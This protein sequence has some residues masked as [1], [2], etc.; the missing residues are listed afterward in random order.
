MPDDT[1][2]EPTPLLAPAAGVPPVLRDQAG[3]VAAAAALAAGDGPLAVDAERASGFK[4]SGRAYLIQLRRAG[5]GSFL[6]DP[7]GATGLSELATVV[8]SLEWILHSADQDLPCL[9]E[10]GLRPAQLYDTEL[11]GRLAGFER[12][13]LAA[14]VEHTL[15]LGLQKGHGAA[16]WSQRPLPPDWLN[17]AALDVEVL[18]ELYAAMHAELAAQNKTEWAA[19]EFEYIRTLP[20]PPPKPDRWRRTS[21]IHT[22]RKP[23]QLAAVRELW[24]T[25]DQ[26]A[27]DTDIAPGRVLPDA[28]IV[29]AVKA[30]P[31]SESELRALPVFGGPKQRRR[32]GLWFG[33]LQRAQQL[34]A[35]ELPS[36]AAPFAGPPPVSRWSSRNPDAAAR[37]ATARAA[38]TEL[39]AE[40]AVPVENLLAPDLVRRMC[41]DGI[42]DVGGYLESTSARPWQ[43]ELT[44]PRLTAALAG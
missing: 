2:T 44:V 22:L 38:L 21:G 14:I 17:Y 40:V 20:P 29:T 30:A 33:A 10:L 31:A 4:Y 3:I 23:R 7:I 36:S 28:A 15:G 5:A 42:T 26:L 39:S 8:N 18:P 27:R 9:A 37:L 43:R 32:A 34:P 13:G 12:V 19:Q 11:A 41:W 6:I 1:T 35:N 16:D 24:T 25:R